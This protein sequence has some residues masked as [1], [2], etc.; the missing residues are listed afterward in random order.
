MKQQY[1]SLKR[2]MSRATGGEKPAQN[3]LTPKAVR[4]GWLMR[5]NT[6]KYVPHQ[7][8]NEKARRVHQMANHTHGY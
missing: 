3:W 4:A 6:S 5:M 7:G 1:K 2:V 8:A